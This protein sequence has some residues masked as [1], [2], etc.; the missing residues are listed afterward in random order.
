MQPPEPPRSATLH[1]YPDA[2]VVYLSGQVAPAYDR[3]GLSPAFRDDLV[4]SI[5]ETCKRVGWEL[6][7]KHL[8]STAQVIP[9]HPSHA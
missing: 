6:S 4:R 2:L 1:V 7:E 9:P 3:T 8:D 5:R